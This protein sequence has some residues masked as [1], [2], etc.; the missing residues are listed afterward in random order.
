MR[1]KRFHL[2]CRGASYLILGFTVLAHAQEPT[3]H[4]AGKPYRVDPSPADIYTDDKG[5]EPHMPGAFYR[6]ELTDGVS[7]PANYRAAEWVGWR[8]TSYAEP[9]RVTVDL[10]EPTWIERIE[11]TVCGA[12]KSIEPPQRIDVAIRGGDFPYDAFVQTG[13]V[14]SE[15]TYAPG[16]PRSYHF[17]M[18]D[19]R[20]MA[21]QVRLSFEERTWSYLFV[22]EI[23]L[24]GGEAGQPPLLPV[25][26]LFL[27]A[28][29]GELAGAAALA[30]EGAVGSAALLDQPTDSLQFTV[31]LPAGDYTIRVRSLAKE[32][33][34]FSELSPRLGDAPMR[35]QPVT[36][37]V[38]TWQRSHFTQAAD[39]PARISL[40]L[41][42]GAGAYVDRVRIHLLTLNEPIKGLR[43]FGE[44][45][46]LVEG[47]RA[48]CIIALDDE[49][50]FGD[51]ARAVADE[52][53]RRSGAKPPIKRGTDVTEEDF[54]ASH[55]I[56]LGDRRSNLAVLKA[57]PNAWN[58][59]PTPPEDGEPQLYVAV[60][61]K[62]AGTNVVV[63]GGVDEAQVKS[64]LAAFTERLQGEG[65]LTLP[66]TQLPPPRLDT[67]RERYRE[68]AVESG[69][70]LRQG[71]IRQLE[72]QWKAHG[73]DV[74]LML[75]YR[76]IE[77]KDSADTIRPISRDGFIEAELYK[78]LCRFDRTEHH[79]SLTRLQRLQ[80]TNTLLHM[81]RQC[82]GIFDWETCGRAHHPPEETARLLSERE[83][84]IAN[85]HQTFPV[86]T[87][88]TVGDYFSQYYELPE[89][90]MWLRWA[91][92][93]M[94]GQLRSSKPQCDCWG[95]QDITMIHTA[96]YAAAT[97]R[98]DYFDQD[99]VHQFLRL[100]FISHDNLGGGVG[101]G[102]V[103]AYRQ[104]EGG[105]LREANA[106]NW[107]AVTSDRL[108]LSRIDPEGVL[109]VYVHPL[110]PMWYEQYGEEAAV[111]LE[112]CFDK[113]TFRNALDPQ[114]AYLMIDGLSRGY[115]GHW[116][117][118]SIL[119]FTDNGRVWLCE[120]D[121]LKGDPKDHNTVTF[122]R[123]GES[124]RPGMLS[125][126][127]ARFETDTWGVTT[128]RTP[129]YCGL[130][131]DRH[132]I[133][134]RHSDTF[135]LIDEMTAR[136]P[137]AY[138]MKS[139]FRS[140]GEA[141]L[142]SRVW[143]VE[144]QGGERLFLHA[145]GRGRLRQATD[146]EDAKN[147]KAYEFAE[148]VP[149]LL[150][151]ALTREMNVGDRAALSSYF[152]AGNAPQP[153]AD[154]R[155]LAPG[156][157]I[158]NGPLKAIV[159]VRKLEVAG[160]KAI[161]RDFVVGP[162]HLVLIDG[163]ELSAGDAGV[164][165]SVPLSLALNLPAGEGIV[166]ATA[167][168]VLSVTA[169]ADA[170]FAL[171][172]QL[173]SAR[174]EV[175]ELTVPPGRHALKG[176]F[177]RLARA[178]TEAYANAWEA[179]DQ[180]E[181]PPPAPPSNGVTPAF[182]VALASEITALAK[183]DLTGDKAPECLVGCADGT[184]VAVD[185]AGRELWRHAFG[186]RVND[187]TTADLDADGKAEI[188]CGV[189]DEH[190]HVMKPDGTELWKRFFEAQR[191][192]GG[193]EGHVRVV[194]AADFDGDGVPEIAV[195]GANSMFYVLDR[196][197]ELKESNGQAWEAMTQHKA[198]AIGA[199]DVTGD[200]QL[201]LL[202]GY[203]YFGRKIV[204]FADTG[205][206]RV[207]NLGGCIS[208][209]GTITSADVDGDGTP[210]AIFADRD[211]QV[212]ACRKTADAGQRG[213]PVEV[214]WQKMIGDDAVSK[215]LAG[216]FDAD[217]KPEILLASHSGF[218]ALL[219]ADGAVRWIRYADNQV[220]DAA[221]LDLADGRAGLVR[222]STDG[223]VVVYDASG[224]ELARWQIGSPVRRVLP[225][226]A[227]DRQ[228][229][230]AAVGDELQCGALTAP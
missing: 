159:G 58:F 175:V 210:E 50:R 208:G 18:D 70:W 109:G 168:T 225:A 138:D 27:E 193:I 141:R 45:T 26:D 113:I 59:V 15:E 7:G 52:I 224:V 78:I 71:A 90:D 136:Q 43:D 211:G 16:P 187:L 165:S 230:F 176:G 170:E 37:S 207:S 174:G 95:Y 133:W 195:G 180:A 39:G 212:T 189:E 143:T 11:V 89:A 186:A 158:A 173:V 62:G 221:R 22:D 220:T 68:L 82:Q 8:D 24:L 102:D 114:Q 162:E 127:Q 12:G 36:N 66:W 216:D 21:S 197:G 87:L 25:Q 3:N 38:F 167:E 203:T 145:P 151:H 13:Q 20:W 142:D 131:W 84:T 48:R 57:S 161:G 118:N 202:C 28:E 67:G 214:V 108:D 56:A 83:P 94:Q 30:V 110:E 215:A 23:K 115:H 226:T 19:C 106:R 41:A 166:E 17:V 137:G 75:A 44:D 160:L 120:G 157:M 112:Q 191:S 227:E 228:L 185:A 196:D 177:S 33:D 46:T 130:D 184:L 1:S 132:L 122:M 91:D 40:R 152:Y 79:G 61:P 182:T 86:Y 153:L 188:I 31:P 73:D 201:E 10:G 63:L 134:H 123:N 97:G 96:R 34:T 126:L 35:P 2:S 77:Y 205:K 29:D 121:Y 217:G 53:E 135:M 169:D 150:T 54:G 209:C 222:S 219:G 55:V 204:D 154:V 164:K 190:V 218:L 65:T 64:S 163:T 149:Q 60:D 156:A 105:D 111:P 213:R 85:N 107:L 103:G 80:L 192:Q 200:G 124:G 181:G 194:L 49:G 42:E 69:K 47:G 98:W 119:R 206:G 140:L 74:F 92:T 99:P 14:T 101:Y 125:G 117:G 144:Q 72:N 81:S 104:P 147:W 198:S 229:L 4:G 223:S 171:D 76:Y 199:A 51:Q 155:Q 146:P 116:D 129:D 128:T 139:R 148:P 88:L 9:I 5:P 172:G 6:G 178:L 100:R 32:P 179:A 93:F 183:G